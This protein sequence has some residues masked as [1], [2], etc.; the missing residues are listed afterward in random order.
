VSG[1]RSVCRLRDKWTIWMGQAVS[2]SPQSATKMLAPIQIA[3]AR[4]AS[5][6][7]FRVSSTR[8]IC[9]SGNY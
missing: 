8:G 4:I 1:G 9:F 2:G 7:Q 6:I 3:E 5:Y